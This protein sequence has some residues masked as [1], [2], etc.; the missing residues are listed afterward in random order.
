[1]SVGY[2]NLWCKPSKLSPH[3]YIKQLD[4]FK[5]SILKRGM[6]HRIIPLSLYIAHNKLFTF[7]TNL[8]LYEFHATILYL[9]R[10]PAIQALAQNYY[11]PM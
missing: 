4:S 10:I 5:C 6:I 8:P 7:H 9:W 11:P 3:G 1:M 2:R